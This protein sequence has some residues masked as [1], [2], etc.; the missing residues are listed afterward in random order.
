MHVY[1]YIYE[2]AGN[3]SLLFNKKLKYA[4]IERSEI[5][6]K[7][8]KCIPVRKYYDNVYEYERAKKLRNFIHQK[9]TKRKTIVL[10]LL[11]IISTRNTIILFPMLNMNELYMFGVNKREY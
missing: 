10:T 6:K 2:K 3:P 4:V 11:G 5:S 1:T 7:S 9:K 8:Y